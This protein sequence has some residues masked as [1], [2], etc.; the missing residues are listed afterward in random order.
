MPAFQ[1]GRLGSISCT[2]VED[3]WWTCGS[4]TAF[5]PSTR[6]SLQYHFTN[7]HYS[8]TSTCN[9]LLL[10]EGQRGEVLQPSKKPCY[11]GNRGALGIKVLI[12][13]VK[14]KLFHTNQKKSRSLVRTD[15]ALHNGAVY[16]NQFRMALTSLFVFG[17]TAPSGPRPPHSRGL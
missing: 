9:T 11:F 12:S 16:C 4:G 6:F 2:S 17:A 1:R 15:T 5:S 13:S 10:P 14:G 7:I 3:F 8:C